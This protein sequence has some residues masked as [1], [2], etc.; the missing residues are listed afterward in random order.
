MRTAATVIKASCGSCLS[1]KLIAYPSGPV[2][3]DPIWIERE[4]VLDARDRHPKK[5][6]LLH[7]GSHR[8]TG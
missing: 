8:R 4:M 3:I 7:A 2:R 6:S 5:G 1:R